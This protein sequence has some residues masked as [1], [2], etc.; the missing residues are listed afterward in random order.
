MAVRNKFRLHL[1]VWFGKQKQNGQHHTNDRLNERTYR[2]VGLGPPLSLSLCVTFAR[3][4]VQMQ[5]DFFL[6]VEQKC[7]KQTDK[8]ERKKNKK[9]R[10]R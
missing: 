5:I 8:N 4:E 2:Q 9:K 6:C 1:F 7:V 10:R 3:R